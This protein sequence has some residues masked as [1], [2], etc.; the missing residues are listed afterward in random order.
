MKKENEIRD[1]N[2]ERD[3]RFGD[4]TRRDFDKQGGG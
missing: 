3:T 2:Y 1:C 4:F